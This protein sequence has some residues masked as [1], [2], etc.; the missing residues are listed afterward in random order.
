MAQVE[1]FTPNGVIAGLTPRLPLVGDGPTLEEPLPLER[2]R[3]YPVDGSAPSHLGSITVT[4][5]DVLVVVVPE[6]DVVIHQTWYDIELEVGPY[7]L[8]GR[9]GTPPGFDPDRALSRPGG[10]FVPLR[11]AVITLRDR[12]GTGAAERAHVKVNRFAVEGVASTLMLGF[13]F[14]GARFTVA[15]GAPTA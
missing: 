5:D 13:H 15:A 12:A 3:W 9:L 7:H 14:P 11:D 6:P 10:S 1:I 4:P 8:R 2:A